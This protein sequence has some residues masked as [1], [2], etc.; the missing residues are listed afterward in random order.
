[1]ADPVAAIAAVLTAA[2]IKTR[3][4]NAPGRPLD[5]LA[6]VAAGGQPPDVIVIDDAHRLPKAAGRCS[7]RSSQVH[8]LTFDSCSPRRD[9]PLA[10]VKL[11]LSD[12]ITVLRADVLR[13]DDDEG[14]S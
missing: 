11:G 12:S 5:L 13:F 3:T 10:T 7:R 2:V 1:M 14:P 8:P 6:R 9:M 4:R